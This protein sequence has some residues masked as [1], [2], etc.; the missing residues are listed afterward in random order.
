MFRQSGSGLWTTFSCMRKPQVSTFVINDIIFNPSLIHTNTQN[1]RYQR[2]YDDL[3]DEEHAVALDLFTLE[4]E[5]L[6]DADEI[7]SRV[8]RKQ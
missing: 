7:I 4:D 3:D 2:L 6:E 8:S 1:K 5:S